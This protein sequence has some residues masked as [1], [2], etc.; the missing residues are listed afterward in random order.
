L[1]TDY[2][3]GSVDRKK[4][5]VLHRFKK[6]YEPILVS[7]KEIDEKGVRENDV[8]IIPFVAPSA[9]ERIGYP[10]QKPMALLERIIQCASNKGDIVLDPFM[11][12]GTT[13]AV[14][15]KLG[16]Q[17]IG[18]DQSVQAVKVTEFRL[19]QQT[20]IFTNL[21][22]NSYTLQLYKYD[23]DALRDKEAF[24]F[25]TWIIQQFGGAPQNKKGGDDG[26]DGKTSTVIKYTDNQQKDVT[27]GTP[28]QVKRSEKVGVN[29]VKN[30]SVSAEQYN[31]ALFERNKKAGNPV[32]YIIAFSFGKGA[33]E[34]TAR[35]RN[36]KGIVI[37]LVTVDKIVPLAKKPN[38]IVTINE[39]S[40]DAKGMR[41][42][43]FIA[44]GNSDAGVEFYSWDFTYN[45]TKGF[46]P[47]VIRD[48][49]GK[50]ITTF[51]AG[52]YNIAVKAVDN[53]GLESIEVIKLKVNGVV[54]RN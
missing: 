2:T 42:I 38:I 51:A 33:V 39:L 46:V 18:I 28:I 49:E 54:E 25:E 26:V 40:R 4:G 52:A 16:R 17:W 45:A 44:A 7:D 1:Y 15:D 12:G 10:T 53:D 6:G 9:K 43:E 50:Q 5:G 21:Y 24:E 22:A 27:A 31:G 11:G 29:V 35:L 23:Y 34:E 19:Q 32:G 41:E 37:E 36:Q 14:A 3:E 47:S 48:T 8:W 30:F 20:D 13:M